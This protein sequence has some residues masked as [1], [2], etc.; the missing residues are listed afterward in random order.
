[1]RAMDDSYRFFE[2]IFVINVTFV[3]KQTVMTIDVDDRLILLTN[4][5]GINAPGLKELFNVVERFGKVLMI[6]SSEVMSGMSQAISSKLPIRAKLIEETDN[7]RIYLSTGTPTDNVKLAINSL[8]ER[9][10]DYVVSG[11]NQGSNSS[12]SVLYSGTMGAVI[13]GCL[14]GINSVGFSLNSYSSKADYSACVKY[15][16][17]VMRRVIDVPL[18]SDVCLNVNIPAVPSNE[19]KGVKI[20]RQAKGN[21]KEEFDKRVDP[22]GRNYYWLTGIYDNHEPDAEDTDEW[23]LANNFVSVV[24]ITVDMTHFDYLKV[25]RQWQPE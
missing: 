15:V 11:I 17:M 9:K 23:A 2:P 1:M 19:I 12:V 20:C 4:D 14:Y 8:L 7:H 13:E 21:W 10:P 3:G 5:D 25:L 18:A 24:P 22:Y 16:E 6:S